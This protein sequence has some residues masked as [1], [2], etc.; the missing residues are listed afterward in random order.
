VI[1]ISSVL[2]SALGRRYCVRILVHPRTSG[3]KKGLVAVRIFNIS[4]RD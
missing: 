4:N 1:A 3:T 2:R